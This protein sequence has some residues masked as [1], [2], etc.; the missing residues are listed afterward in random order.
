M[1]QVTVQEQLNCRDRARGAVEVPGARERGGPGRHAMLRRARI[2]A[3]VT[4]GLPTGCRYAAETF[5]GTMTT[6]TGMLS[7][8][9]RRSARRAAT[10]VDA[11]TASSRPVAY[12]GS[13][14]NADVSCDIGSIGAGGVVVPGY[15]GPDARPAGRSRGRHVQRRPAARLLRRHRSP[16]ACSGRRRCTRRRRRSRRRFASERR[17]A[18]RASPAARADAHRLRARVRAVPLQPHVPRRGRRIP[19]RVVGTRAVRRAARRAV[20]CRL[21]RS[22]VPVRA[23][24]DRARHPHRPA[25]AR[26]R[27]STSA[28]R[29]VR[30]TCSRSSARASRRVISPRRCPRGSANPSIVK[31]AADPQE[32]G[33]HVVRERR[34]PGLRGGDP[35]G[36]AADSAA[37][38]SRH[39]HRPR[40]PRT[41]PRW[42]APTWPLPY[43]PGPRGCRDHRAEPE[44]RPSGDLQ[45]AAEVRPPC[46]GRRD[47]H[48]EVARDLASHRGFPS[49][50]R[51]PTRGRR[52]TDRR[53]RRR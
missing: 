14:A 46:L 5:Y 4:A 32:P 50:W 20:R 47:A 26:R 16:G 1:V 38:V 6:Y 29:T 43:A 45:L 15:R 23:G 18:R 31:T 3:L 25:G 49:H 7:G 37:G 10:A 12:P 52:G 51:G 35:G 8:G 36:A 27:S 2:A 11:G 39:R 30:V 28:L 48:A 19:L 9:R 40:R 34:V 24:A 33:R 44:R 53:C 21:G 13:P 17:A 22:A 41:R 42:W